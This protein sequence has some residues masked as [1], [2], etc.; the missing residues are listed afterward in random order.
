VTGPSSPPESSALLH[1]ALAANSADLLAY[2]ERR[3]GVRDDAADLLGETMLVA[4]RR[5]SQLPTQPEQTRMWLF[6]I[7][8][9][10]LLNYRRGRRRHLAVA[11]ALRAELATASVSTDSALA[12]DVRRAIEQLPAKLAE[13][14]RLVHWDGFSLADAAELLGIPAATARGRYARARTQLSARLPAYDRSASRS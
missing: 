3:V 2:L 10:T 8:R 6:T 4:W 5:V 1:V 11:E 9:N 12:L 7:A 13:L 14:V